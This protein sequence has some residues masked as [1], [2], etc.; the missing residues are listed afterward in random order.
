MI[1]PQSARQ[2]TGGF[3]VVHPL[4]H[5]LGIAQGGEPV[6]QKDKTLALAPVPLSEG[7]AQI[8]PTRLGAVIRGGGFADREEQMA[9]RRH[10][11]GMR[12]TG[13]G[14]APATGQAV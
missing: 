2:N 3:G 13:R 5:A 12:A 10:G 6:E 14:A 8:L 9:Q 4:A 1:I 11:E 7:V